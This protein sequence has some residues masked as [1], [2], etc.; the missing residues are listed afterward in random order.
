MTPEDIIRSEQI[1]KMEFKRDIGGFNFDCLF[2]ALESFTKGT[3]KDI[4][5]FYSIIEKGT[6]GTIEDLTR[7]SNFY[8]LNI[9]KI[10]FS[11]I[12]DF[13]GIQDPMI[14]KELGIISRLTRRQGFID[15]IGLKI[16]LKESFKFLNEFNRK[17][18]DIFSMPVF[19][20]RNGSGIVEI[21]Y[22]KDYQGHWYYAQHPWNVGSIAGMPTVFKKNGNIRYKPMDVEVTINRMS[23]QEL[24]IAYRYKNHKWEF[25]EKTGNVKVNNIEFATP[26]LLK[27]IT[28]KKSSS[29]KDRVNLIDIFNTKTYQILTNKNAE[30]ISDINYHIERGMNIGALITRDVKI[31]NLLWLREGQ[32]FRIPNTSLPTVLHCSWE[33]HSELLDPFRNFASEILGFNNII[34]E[35]EK[36]LDDNKILTV[37]IQRQRDNLENIVAERTIELKEAQDELIQKK[38]LASMGTLSAGIAHNFKNL[39]K[40]FSETSDVL[41]EILKQIIYNEEY[42][43]KLGL[44]NEQTNNFMTFINRKYFSGEPAPFI[45]GKLAIERIREFGS[46]ENLNRRQLRIL[47]NSNIEKRDLPRLQIFL[48]GGDSDGILEVIRISYA[49]SVAK[50]SITN[51]LDRGYKIVNDIME[52]TN[53]AKQEPITVNLN[54][55]VED[56]AD[57]VKDE[58]EK[59]K[60][61]IDVNL[62]KKLPLVILNDTVIK[63]VISQFYSNSLYA[64]QGIVKDRRITLRTYENEGDFCF[65]F[66]D[67][68][69]GIPKEIQYKVFDAFFTTKKGSGGTGF[70]LCAAYNMII[71]FGGISLDSKP[72]RTT[73]TV[74]IVKDYSYTNKV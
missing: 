59:L 5:Q 37:S 36:Q 24:A 48:E 50:N 31:S 41:S 30:L 12:H 57:S 45:D 55:I 54:D 2:S 44:D 47:A 53:L 11:L 52:V 6:N 62:N 40:G 38:T 51:D 29:I 3:G 69:T 18:N 19:N 32:I 17:Y 20:V 49:L 39:L 66:T 67:T 35:L 9:G 33:P 70:G 72:G 15:N 10:I 23:L 73:F 1:D 8:R 26:A 46:I 56:F 22:I 58:L 42:F 43:Y 65:D 61:Q 71:P 34:R 4:E 16:G 74:R 63:N 27:K 64:M 68:G 60:I 14:F 28:V 21:E 7:W 25:D 13:L